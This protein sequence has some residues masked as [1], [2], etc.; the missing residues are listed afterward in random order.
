M[1]RLLYRPAM[2]YPL[3]LLSL[4]LA[5]ALVTGCEE[6]ETTTIDPA[7]T[8]PAAGP[9]VDSTEDGPMM[10]DPAMP[11]T[12]P[13]TTGPGAAPELRTQPGSELDPTMPPTT[14][15]S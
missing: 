13:P 1:L 7:T 4:V 11:P 14:Q 3:S 15:P 6:E 9:G 5:T 8:P 12:L 10:G 2:R